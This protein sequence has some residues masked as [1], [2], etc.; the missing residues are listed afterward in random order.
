MN[1]RVVRRGMLGAMAAL[2][3]A[4]WLTAVF[5]PAWAD[6]N[7]FAPRQHM[8]TLTNQAREAHDKADVELNTLLSRYAKQ[9]SLA[10][11]AKGYLFH[12]DN[13]TLVKLLSRYHWSIGGENVGVGSNVDD[14]QAAFMASPPHR[15]NILRS[16]FSRVAIGTVRVNG[17]L[18]A[19]V[20]FYG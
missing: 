12:S 20:I 11:A 17:H 13:S 15:R 9:H 6:T 8:L 19:T 3:L 10:M 5:A 18:W 4:G 1:V 16:A 7:R 2:L 14:L